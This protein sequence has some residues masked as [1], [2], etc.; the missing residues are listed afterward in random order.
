[1]KPKHGR[2]QQ[3]TL[4]EQEGELNWD[5]LLQ[6]CSFKV[7]QGQEQRS[8]SF[9]EVS[10]ELEHFSSI[11]NQNFL[12]RGDTIVKLMQYGKP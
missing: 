3:N 8:S 1:M 11:I 12:K 2:W 4:A 10:P 6:T 7:I 5:P 9:S